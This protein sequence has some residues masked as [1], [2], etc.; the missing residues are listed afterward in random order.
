MVGACDSVERNAFQKMLTTLLYRMRCCTVGK[1]MSDIGSTGKGRNS[2]FDILCK[3][4]HCILESN[5]ECALAEWHYSGT[6]VLVKVTAAYL[7]RHKFEV[8]KVCCRP[9]DI[10]GHHSLDQFCLHNCTSAIIAAHKT[11]HLSQPPAVS[12]LTALVYT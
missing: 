2:R 4:R 9:K 11:A 6:I 3:C 5:G 7:S 8:D 12:L 1:A 10:V